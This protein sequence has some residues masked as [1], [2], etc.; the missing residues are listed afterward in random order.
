MGFNRLKRV[1]KSN[2]FGI[3][4][5]FGESNLRQILHFEINAN[6]FFDR[7]LFKILDMIKCLSF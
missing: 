5:P 1:V 6:Q 4:V 3:I 2:F 7:E